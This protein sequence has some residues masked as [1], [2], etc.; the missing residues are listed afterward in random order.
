MVAVSACPHPFQAARVD[1]ELPAGLTVA[2]MIE[3]VQSD[4]VLRMHAHVYIGGDYVPRELW[5][6]VR[7]KPGARLAIRI[8]PHDGGGEGG[9]DPLR[10]VLTIA[11]IAATFLVPELLPAK[12]FFS[13]KL[14]IGLVQAGTGITGPLLVNAAEPPK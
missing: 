13:T 14:G 2:E 6:R 1:L 7:P 12:G 3:E 9:K 10:I 5:H 11:V 4:P 8:V